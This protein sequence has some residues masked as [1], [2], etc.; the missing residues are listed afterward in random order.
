MEGKQDAGELA[1]RLAVCAA[2]A[3]ALLYG[4]EKLCEGKNIPLWE[5][6]GPWLKANRLQA[7]A[8]GA[9]VLYGAWTAL[10]KSEPKGEEGYTACP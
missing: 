3:L 6:Y 4:A 8:I 1:A 7:A 9:A 5:K 10:E 2:A